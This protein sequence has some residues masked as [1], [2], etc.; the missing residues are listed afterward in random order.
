MTNVEIFEIL[1]DIDDRYII[2]ARRG[3]KHMN[4]KKIISM[5]AC[6]ALIITAFSI[7]SL[8]V[9]KD[10]MTTSL[11]VVAAEIGKES[12]QFGATM[13]KIINVTNGNVIMYDYVGIWVYDINQEELVGF[14]DFRPINMTGIQGDPCVFVDATEDG[15]YVRFYMSDGSANFLY[16]VEKN[17][18][19]KVNDYDDI[20]NKVATMIVSDSMQISGYSQ[21]YE[22]NDGSYIS[23]ILD[24]GDGIDELRYGDLVIVIDK[25]GVRKEYRPFVK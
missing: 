9:Q 17:K 15:K 16:D 7:S 3:K 24:T 23:Y 11:Q 6:M 4:V 10:N 8:W 14:C 2:E 1:S 12:I 19:K 22:L 20:F 5:A 25:D 21:T 18:Y 13:P